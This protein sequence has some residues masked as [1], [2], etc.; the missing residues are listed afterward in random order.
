VPGCPPPS[1]GGPPCVKPTV[2][3]AAAQ[4]SKNGGPFPAKLLGETGSLK[5]DRVLTPHQYLS[6]RLSTSRSYGAN[7][8]SF[9]SGS[10]ITN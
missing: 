7:N 8:V 5:L 1:E 10:P 3:P 9:D 4:L 6:A 2:F